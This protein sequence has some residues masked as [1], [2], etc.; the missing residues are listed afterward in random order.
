MLTAQTVKSDVH[1]QKAASYI[2]RNIKPPPFLLYKDSFFVRK[3]SIER[4]QDVIFQK[5][6]EKTD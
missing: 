2:S 3:S 1:T 4:S 6:S 5:L